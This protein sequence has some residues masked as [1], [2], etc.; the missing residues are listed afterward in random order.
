MLGAMEPDS[1]LVRGLV[2]NP[3]GGLS[4]ALDRSTTFER[5][6]GG[7][8]PYG[9]G[10]A[11]VAAEAE[12]LLGA[13]E[14]AEATVFASGMTAWTCICLSL[15]GEGSALALATSGYY[16]L[17]GFASGILERFGVEVRRFD[18][19]DRDSF[20][21]AC[22]GAALAII[23]T[24]SNPLVTL[25]DI[26][27]A[28][29]DAHAGG[30][31]LCC[32]S[33]FA[34]PLLQRPLD[35][36]ADLAWQSATKYLAGHSD[37]LAGVVTT[38]DAGPARAPRVDA[39]HHRRRARARRGLAAAAR[40]AHAARAAASPGRD[41]LRARPSAR[42]A[43]LRRGRALPGPRRITPITGSRCARCPAAREACWPSSWPTAQARDTA[44]RPCGSCA[45]RPA[46]A[47]S[48]R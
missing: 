23:E 8:S 19:R 15:L 2:D 33:T 10:H 21:R 18:A 34:T 37:V 24:P 14:D 22:D 39:P 1:L 12:A 41:G 32:D 29:S 5:E 4:P 31:L 44:R 17:E 48:R 36:G 16:S 45:G 38:R 27:G 13:L 25:T 26:A 7:G 28:A 46:S 9:R 3:S 47:A 42:D 6:P 20:R 11:P 43:S 40:P 30:A 35:L